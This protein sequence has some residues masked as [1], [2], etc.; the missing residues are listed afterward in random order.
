[1]LIGVQGQT[2]D[3]YYLPFTSLKEDLIWRGEIG[4]IVSM[5]LFYID[6]I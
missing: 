6:M 3:N 2:E 5:S 4:L 1:M